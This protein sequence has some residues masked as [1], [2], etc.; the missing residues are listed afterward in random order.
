LI[1]LKDIR[2]CF[3][4]II[5]STLA[6]CDVNGTPN[7][8]Y[9][10]QVYYVSDNEIALSYQFF[11]K[12]RQNI[13]ENPHATLIVVDP[14]NNKQFSLSIVYMHTLETGALFERMKA[15]LAGIASINGMENVFRLKGADIYKVHNIQLL[16]YKNFQRP[17]AEKGKNHL[18]SLR[19]I[20]E[21]LSPIEDLSELFEKTLFLLSIHFSF[22]HSIF[23]LPDESCNKLFAVESF[24]YPFSGVGSEF[25]IG[26]G[27]IGIAAK[28]RSHIR[29]SN[30]SSQYHYVQAMNDFFR[31]N[32][33]ESDIETQIKFPGL[34]N[35]HSQIAVPLV[36]GQHLVG[37]LYAES[38]IDH[39]FSYEDEDALI[40]LAFYLA[41][42]INQLQIHDELTTSDNTLPAVTEETP[43]LRATATG[44]EKP[45]QIR[46]FPQTKSVFINEDYL[47]KGVAGAI[48]WSI[49]QL[50][51]SENRTLF[52]NKELR[53]NRMI[54]LPEIGDNLEARLVLLKR[55][56]NERCD[57]IKIEKCGRGM[58][59]LIISR[60]LVLIET[61]RT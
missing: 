34:D 11:N 9:I 21:A 22:D 3:E 8:S 12:T 53:L 25:P 31:A 36:K 61:P 26:F 7:V 17:M 46:Y 13:I 49:L 40:S 27:V 29:I 48:L 52:S 33:N 16:P 47:I 6:T 57:F 24:G 18:F 20:M 32:R 5:P 19:Q 50:Y 54:H 4:G 51:I 42:L 14:N 1:S 38:Q 28:M 37:V 59:E 44:N 43:A 30:I 35:P 45:L 2:E 56:L 39:F 60:K 23:F 15:Q 58:F 55:R 10:S 41:Q